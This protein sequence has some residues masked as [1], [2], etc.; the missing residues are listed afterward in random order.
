MFAVMEVRH[1]RIFKQ[2][3]SLFRPNGETEDTTCGA[4]TCIQAKLWQACLEISRVSGCALLSEIL[5]CLGKISP[6]LG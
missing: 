3:H 1:S 6:C 5:S 4:E 2:L